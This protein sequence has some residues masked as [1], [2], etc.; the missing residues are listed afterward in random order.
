VRVRVCVCVRCALPCCLLA[1]SIPV[2]VEGGGERE[3]EGEAGIG[4]ERDRMG[5][6]YIYIPHA[7][8]IYM[9]RGEEC[10]CRQRSY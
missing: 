3:T 1:G 2:V 5:G 9:G 10:L 4:G 7:R 8:T 6:M